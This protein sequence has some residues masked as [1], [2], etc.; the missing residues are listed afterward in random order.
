[1]NINTD[2]KSGSS[3]TRILNRYKDEKQNKVVTRKFST[4]V[5]EP[6]KQKSLSILVDHHHHHTQHNNGSKTVKQKETQKKQ[7][8]KKMY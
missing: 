2:E 5:N 7:R 1:M 4:I 3:L 8:I 6:V